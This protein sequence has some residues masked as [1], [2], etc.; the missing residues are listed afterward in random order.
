MA[1]TLFDIKFETTGFHVKEKG[2]K[3]S[4]SGIYIMRTRADFYPT[5]PLSPLYKKHYVD[6]RGEDGKSI[7][8]WLNPCYSHQIA[9]SETAT[10]EQVSEFILN[11]FPPNVMKTLESCLMQHPTMVG[12]YVSPLIRH[13]RFMPDWKLRTKDFADL[14]GTT[15]GKFKRQGLQSTKWRQDN[16][17]NATVHYRWGCSYRQVV[18][19]NL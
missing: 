19:R 14:V 8:A 3:R 5:D 6:H 16:P 18:F 17:H 9:T 10:P 2:R 12:H 4:H 13:R 15:R 7:G 11:Q 1:N